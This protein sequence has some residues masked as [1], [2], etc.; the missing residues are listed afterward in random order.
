MNL[1]TIKMRRDR[2]MTQEDD[3]L[4][5]AYMAGYHKGREEVEAL[6]KHINFLTEMD[7]QRIAWRELVREEF[8]LNLE[9]MIEYEDEIKRGGINDNRPT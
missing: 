1:I 3:D 6:K 5:M 4:S 2:A 9:E 8:G 7:R